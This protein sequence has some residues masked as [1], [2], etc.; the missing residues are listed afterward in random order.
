MI[1]MQ[2]LKDHYRFTDDDAELLRSLQPL[3]AQHQERFTGSEFPVSECYSVD[4]NVLNGSIVER[5]GRV[6]VR[7]RDLWLGRSARST[8]AACHDDQA[9]R[10]SNCQDENGVLVHNGFL[11]KSFFFPDGILGLILK[12]DSY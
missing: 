2:E 3:A 6:V 12:N 10:E 11:Q 5:Y 9:D 8:C 7:R 4:L 1:T